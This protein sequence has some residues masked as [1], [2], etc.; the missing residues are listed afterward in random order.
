M[1]NIEKMQFSHEKMHIF[2]DW[3]HLEDMKNH[4]KIIEN[5]HKM[6]SQFFIILEAIFLVHLGSTFGRF[7]VDFGPKLHLK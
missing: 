1:Q 4:Q 6:Q 5:Q 2:E 3:C 7:W